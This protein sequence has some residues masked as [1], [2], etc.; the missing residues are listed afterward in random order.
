MTCD[1]HFPSRSWKL[2]H[3]M[4]LI[5]IH[6]IFSDYLSLGLTNVPKHSPRP[7]IGINLVRSCDNSNKFDLIIVS[8]VLEHVVDNRSFLTFVKSFAHSNSLI[9]LKF[10]LT[11]WYAKPSSP[12]PLGYSSTNRLAAIYEMSMSVFPPETL[13]SILFSNSIFPFTLNSIPRAL[14]AVSQL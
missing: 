11:S 6:F 8:H 9:F 10:W 4:A 5:F 13:H 1:F 2:V 14:C 12:V 3:T 7:R